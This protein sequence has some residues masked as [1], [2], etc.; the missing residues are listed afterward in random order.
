M[1]KRYSVTFSP[2][3]TSRFAAEKIAQAFGG[4]FI[5]VDL[6]REEG[7]E[8]QAEPESVCIVSVPCYGGRIPPTAAERLARRTGGS[9][10]ADASENLR[11]TQAGRP[12]SW[13]PC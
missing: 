12:A 11:K 13:R 4:G 1:E 7:E 3:G 2:T 8:I 9:R 5:A 10:T 6:C